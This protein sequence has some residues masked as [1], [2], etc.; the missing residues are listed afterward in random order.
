MMRELSAGQQL[1]AHRFATYLA[2]EIEHR[3]AQRYGRA[4]LT[5]GEYGDF[6]S[7]PRMPAKVVP[8]RPGQSTE[9]TLP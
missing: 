6:A 9:Y 5:T 3:R 8:L 1:D 4:V 2:D 7:V